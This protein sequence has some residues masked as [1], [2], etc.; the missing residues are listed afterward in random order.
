MPSR[1]RCLTRLRCCARR[2][3]GEALEAAQEAVRIRRQLAEARPDAFLPDLAMSLGA[4]SQCLRALE[5]HADALADLEEAI[6]SLTPR[7]RHIPRAHGCLMGALVRDYV[8]AAG[9]LDRHPDM[10]LLAPV[11]EVFERLQR[12]PPEEGASAPAGE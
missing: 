1:R 12:E 10:A 4:K 7:F 11:L 9:A 5:R 2:R 6:R 3:R 8:A